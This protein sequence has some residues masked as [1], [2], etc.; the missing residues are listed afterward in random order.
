MKQG[1]N[2]PRG[3]RNLRWQPSRMHQ[4]P[5]IKNIWGHQPRPTLDGCN[6]CLVGTRWNP[7]LRKALTPYPTQ[8]N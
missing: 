1:G 8:T 3:T 5:F 7:T 4:N 2:H 6:N